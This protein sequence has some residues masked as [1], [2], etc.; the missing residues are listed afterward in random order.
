MLLIVKFNGDPSVLGKL[1]SSGLVHPGHKIPSVIVDD[2]EYGITLGSSFRYAF[3]ELVCAVSL[4]IH[5]RIESVGS[6]IRNGIR[7]QVVLK[8]VI[9]V[10]YKSSFLGPVINASHVYNL[11]PDPHQVS[12]AGLSVHGTCGI[13]RMKVFISYA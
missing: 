9:G 11:V 1:L 3:S 5:R 2:L 6:K 8:S 10:A 4:F 7:R 12:G 13:S